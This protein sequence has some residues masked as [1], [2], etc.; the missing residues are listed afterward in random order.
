MRRMWMVSSSLSSWSLSELVV[1]GQ[2][3]ETFHF[4]DGFTL[5]L[6]FFFLIFN[7]RHSNV[8]CPLSPCIVSPGVP[9]TS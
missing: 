9:K 6:F 5:R 8:I 1:V 4:G 7:L 3:F 2:G